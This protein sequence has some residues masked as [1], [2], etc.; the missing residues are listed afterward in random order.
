MGWVCR[1][2]TSLRPPDSLSLRPWPALGSTGTSL[3]GSWIAWFPEAKGKLG[4][5]GQQW[6]SPG[7]DLTQGGQWAL[8]GPTRRA[9]PL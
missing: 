9:P 5:P 6:S 8:W 7:F 2:P 4:G 3:Q 1:G